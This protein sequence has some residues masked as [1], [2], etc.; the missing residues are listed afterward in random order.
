MMLL[1]DELLRIDPEKIA[2]QIIDF[3]KNTYAEFGRSGIVVPIS[4]GLDSSVVAALCIRA[5]GSD[6]VI[7]LLLPERQGNPDAKKFAKKLGAFLGIETKTISISKALFAIGTYGFVLSFFPTKKLRDRVAS[8]YMEGVDG[9]VLIDSIRG[10]ESKLRRK[11]RA[12]INSK[13][14]VRL[15][16]L[17]KFAEE[18]DLLVVGSAHR[19]EELVGLFVKFG[20]DDDA[21]IMP[22]KNL[23]RT[24]IVQLAEYLGLPEEIRGRTPNPDIIPGAED[25]YRDMLGIPAATVDLI[26]YGIIHGMAL[27]DIS[28]QLGIDKKKV[29]E[30]DEL[31][32]LSAHMR[33]HSEAPDF[34][35]FG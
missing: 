25:K 29:E 21:D 3:I 13:Q 12:A 11:A 20:I 9:N 23:F 34:D 8:R 1:T 5:V 31:I 24:H 4:G 14:R 15:V 26:L 19:T 32:R 6:R 30:I 18:N 2:Q 28:V 35:I 7:G 33:N 27:E 22:I 16:N 17:Y 10:S